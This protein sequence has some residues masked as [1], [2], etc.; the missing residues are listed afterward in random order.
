MPGSWQECMAGSWRDLGR[1]LGKNHGGI[2]VG[3]LARSWH[4]FLDGLLSGSQQDFCQD[5]G[6]I[7]AG[8]LTEPC[9]ILARSW[10]ES[11]RDLSRN[12]RRIS[13]RFRSVLPK[14]TSGGSDFP[15]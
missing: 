13:A 3:I 9:R 11:W 1:N 6:G 14:A 8:I 7:L 12:Q 2:L 15:E 5:P 10:Q 4:A